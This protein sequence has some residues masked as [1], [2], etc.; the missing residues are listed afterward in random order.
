[1]EHG[2]RESLTRFACQI[3]YTRFQSEI[4]TEGAAY[5]KRTWTTLHPAGGG[6]YSATGNQGEYPPQD[7]CTA[8][9][10]CSEGAVALIDALLARS[11]A[12]RAAK[13]VIVID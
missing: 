9:G 6:T 13:L 8:W 10:N 12:A 1:M 4:D 2:I 7:C 11:L 5:A 3:K